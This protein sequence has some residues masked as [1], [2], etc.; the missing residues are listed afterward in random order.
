MEGGQVVRVMDASEKR[1][2]AASAVLQIRDVY[3][4]SEFFPFRIP[5]PEFEFFPSWIHIKEFKYFRPKNCLSSRKYDP[6]SSSRIRIPDPGGQKGT[7]SGFAT[8]LPAT[9]RPVDNDFESE[10]KLT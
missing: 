9:T 6:G 2:L 3:P 4:G 10:P 8:L 7:G 5:D 1:R